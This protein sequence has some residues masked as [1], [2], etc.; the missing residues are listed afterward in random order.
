M[1]SAVIQGGQSLTQLGMVNNQS[2]QAA[3]ALG[4]PGQIDNLNFLK[5]D[6]HMFWE[7]KYLFGM[8]CIDSDEAGLRNKSMNNLR[9]KNNIINV[10]CRFRWR[11]SIRK[12]KKQKRSAS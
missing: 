7:G 1:S 9:E 6:L 4:K 2:A 12:E 5:M 8:F 10:L 11:W 3:A